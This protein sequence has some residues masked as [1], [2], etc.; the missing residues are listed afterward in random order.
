METIGLSKCDKYVLMTADATFWSVWR[1]KKEE[2]KKK[3]FA[4][5][6]AK[7]QFYVLAPNVESDT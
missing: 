7:G 6:K 4:V 3:G 5:F 2:M 1:Q